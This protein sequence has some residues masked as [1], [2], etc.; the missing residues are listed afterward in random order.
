MTF[1]GVGEIERGVGGRV[2][3]LRYKFEI[4]RRIRKELVEEGRKSS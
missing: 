4:E 1:G 2:H 3:L